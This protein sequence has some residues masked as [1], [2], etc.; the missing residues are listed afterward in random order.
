MED[1]DV[2]SAHLHPDPQ[3]LVT[4]TKTP[5][6][7]FGVTPWTGCLLTND[8]SI[9]KKSWKKLLEVSALPEIDQPETQT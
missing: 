3:L 2:L 1:G 8:L 9:H 6:V 4:D 7:C 5:N